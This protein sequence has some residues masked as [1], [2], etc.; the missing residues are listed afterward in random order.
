MR[1]SGIVVWAPAWFG[2]LSWVRFPRRHI[3]RFSVGVFAVEVDSCCLSFIVTL[4]FG[5]LFLLSPLSSLDG[6]RGS[7]RGLRPIT[8]LN[9]CNNINISY[10][11]VLT[12]VAPATTAPQKGVT[13]KMFEKET[14]VYIHQV[15]EAMILS[16]LSFTENFILGYRELRMQS[17]YLT[18]SEILH[19]THLHF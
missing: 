18:F 7:N 16:S 4:W 5:K 8:L 10:F 6:S 11:H 13:S 17:F 2:G 15:Y 9:N 3:P 14:G 1:A 12:R 19:V